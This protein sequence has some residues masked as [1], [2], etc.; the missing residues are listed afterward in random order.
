[1]WY[2]NA[3][4]Y[5]K[6]HL[7]LYTKN[8][9]KVGGYPTI[10]LNNDTTICIGDSLLLTPGAG[11][12]TY[13][14]NTGSPDESIYAKLPGFYEVTVEDNNG[15]SGSASMNLDTMTC[16][17]D[18]IENLGL[19]SLSF[20]PVPASDQL[21]INFEAASPD[22]MEIRVI[23][24]V[25]KVMFTETHQTYVGVNELEVDLNALATGTYFVWL[26]NSNGSAALKILVE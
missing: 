12:V 7:C 22:E 19:T 9:L 16:H 26:N 6:K 5:Q 21:Y 1:M 20:Y 13:A 4:R 2:V 14:W 17:N 3:Y 8:L 11:F 10:A 23:D 18:G 24:L 15:C 25:G